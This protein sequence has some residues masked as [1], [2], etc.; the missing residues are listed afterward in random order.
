MQKEQNTSIFLVG[1]SKPWLTELLRN[2]EKFQ[3]CIKPLDK[4]ATLYFKFSISEYLKHHF[5][6]NKAKGWI[7]KR[8][9]QKNKARQIFRKTNMI[10]CLFF[11]KFGVLCFL[12]ISVLRFAVLPYYRS[13]QRLM[14]RLLKNLLISNLEEFFPLFFS[15]I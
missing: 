10:K 3:S 7:S 13:S 1:K 5:V 14:T 9:F 11:G 4:N 6:G 8:M 15:S 2:N 12:Q